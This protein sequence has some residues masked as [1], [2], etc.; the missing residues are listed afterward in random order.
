MGKAKLVVGGDKGEK[1]EGS[2]TW[3]RVVVVVGVVD[4]KASLHANEIRTRKD[5]DAMTLQSLLSPSASAPQPLPRGR[6]FMLFVFRLTRWNGSKV[7]GNV[8]IVPYCVR[9][10]STAVPSQQQ[11]QQ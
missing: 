7:D 5:V 3:R 8:S 2:P 10:Y 9:L 11:Q 4:E 6:Y 1:A